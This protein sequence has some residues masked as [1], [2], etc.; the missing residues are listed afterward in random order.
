[1]ML[2]SLLP[3]L[4]LASVVESLVQIEANAFG[5]RHIFGSPPTFYTTASCH[6]KRHDTS[7]GPRMMSMEKEFF[8]RDDEREELVNLLSGRQPMLS[9]LLGPPSVGKTALVRN[10]LSG[11]DADNQKFDA[12]VLNLRGTAI[13]SKYDL[14]TYLRNGARKAGPFWKVV[15]AYLTSIISLRVGGVEVKRVTSA[16]DSD[17]EIEFEGLISSIP[18]SGRAGV[19]VVDEANRLRTLAANEPLVSLQFRLF[20]VS[21]S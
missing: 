2:R 19:L 10:V 15:E 18:R 13:A 8:N 21:D 6:F 9:V 14:F 5:L 3:L 4:L 16:I 7:R 20:V 17:I 12:L 11:V 1:M